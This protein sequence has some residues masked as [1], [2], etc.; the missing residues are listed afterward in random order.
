M[1]D[2]SFYGMLSSAI[3]LYFWQV[4]NINMGRDIYT[5]HE[6]QASV[7][8]WIKLINLDISYKHLVTCTIKPSIKFNLPHQLYKYT[9]Y[10]WK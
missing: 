9:N 4:L 2:M 7:H 5:L 1:D 8:Y 3:M 10:K 6:I